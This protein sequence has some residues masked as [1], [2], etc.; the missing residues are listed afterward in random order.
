MPEG[1]LQRSG[2]RLVVLPAA[3]GHV[4]DA[5]SPLPGQAGWRA[6]RAKQLRGSIGGPHSRTWPRQSRGPCEKGRKERCSAAELPAGVGRPR[7]AKGQ[8]LPLLPPPPCSATASAGAG[9]ASA[10]AACC[11][12]LC[13][14]QRSGQKRSGC[15]KL[16]AL[17]CSEMR[18]SQRTVPLGMMAPLRSCTSRSACGRASGEN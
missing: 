16:L 9:P 14:T 1:R 7:L 12:C 13:C 8:P 3:G 18:D 2:Q 5:S 6:W 17:V 4:L 15:S 11:C 10:P